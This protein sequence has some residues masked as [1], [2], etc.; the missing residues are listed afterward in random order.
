MKNE[1]I[2]K[3]VT[4]VLLLSAQVG[5]AE[6]STQSKF[7]RVE[8]QEE[9]AKVQSFSGVRQRV[10]VEEQSK[11]QLATQEEIFVRP[12]VKTHE[13]NGEVQL[14]ET[15]MS[16]QRA[17]LKALEKIVI[18][19]HALRSLTKERTDNRSATTE[20]MEAR[21]SVPYYNDQQL[22][23]KVAVGDQ[24][25]IL[26]F[27]VSAFPLYEWVTPTVQMYVN[28]VELAFDQNFKLENFQ[29]IS[30][31]Y[32]E[33]TYLSEANETVA[34]SSAI[35]Q[36]G[37]SLNAYTY[38]RSN[39]S[40][41]LLKKQTIVRE[42]IKKNG[43]VFLVVEALSAEHGLGDVFCLD[44]DMGFVGFVEKTFSGKTS[45][46]QDLIKNNTQKDNSTNPV[47]VI[48]FLI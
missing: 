27:D 17:E 37:S 36:V 13:L 1:S 7:K 15:E 20:K 23:S 12:S 28:K 26:S 45:R 24:S 44:E 42:V 3:G 21:S 9:A 34:L 2:L 19:E 30:L 35:P 6:V 8:S 29:N 14:Q 46:V 41:T 16:S 5:V 43:A 33:P 32:L 47:S 25:E 31:G 38:A 4:F 18:L 22:L 10:L 40:V 48:K 39:E 11:E